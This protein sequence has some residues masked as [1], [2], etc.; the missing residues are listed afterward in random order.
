M[1]VLSEQGTLQYIKQ[2]HC[3]IARYGDGEFKICIG[4]CA[5]SQKANINMAI[6]LRQILQNKDLRLLTC[7]PRIYEPRNWPTTKKALFWKQFT[8]P[9]YTRL[10]NDNFVYGSSFIT[11][12]DSSGWSTPDFFAQVKSL[13]EGKRVLLVRGES[14]GF[15][16]NESIFN[17][18]QSVETILGPDRDAY[19]VINSLT[20]KILERSNEETCIV[21]SLGPTATA[22]AS[23]LSKLN[24]WALDLGHFGMF[25]ASPKWKEEQTAQK[26]VI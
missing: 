25:Y 16:K 14:V 23:R 6:E 2:Y 19:K 12:P 17:M 20:Q 8:K 4:N 21:I 13:W 24:R 11:R 15:D 18:T 9:T 1:H 5:K 3:S 26:E 7:I 10:L 22:L